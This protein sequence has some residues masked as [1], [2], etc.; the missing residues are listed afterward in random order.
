MTTIH[1]EEPGCDWEFR[2]D[3]SDMRERVY[4]THRK[5]HHQEEEQ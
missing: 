2:S 3:D 5:Y 4:R 1:C